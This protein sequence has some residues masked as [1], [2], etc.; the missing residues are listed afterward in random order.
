MLLRRRGRFHKQVYGYHGTSKRLAFDIRR[1]GFKASANDYDWLGDG[2]YFWQDAPSRAREWAEQ[3]HGEAP[4]VVGARMTLSPDCMDLLDIDWW[5]TLE[6]AHTLLLAEAARTGTAV[7]RQRSDS[8]AHRL[9][10]A[11]INYSTRLAETKGLRV[12][13]VRAAFVEGQPVYPNSAIYNRSHV[14]ICVIDPTI[15]ND[16]FIVR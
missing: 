12:P 14:Q 1:H 8:G 9:D 2:V 3:H 13:A 4:A 16:V 15:I 10:A 7:P 6:E 5:R 11:V